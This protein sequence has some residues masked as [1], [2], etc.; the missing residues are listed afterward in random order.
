MPNFRKPLNSVLVKVAGPDC[1]M[2]CRY[3]F[4]LEKA[5]MFPS[6]GPRRMSRTVLEALIRQVMAD[7]GAQVAFGWQGG[8]PTLMGAAFFEEVVRLEKRWGRAG[9]T[10]GNGLQTN[11]LRI[12]DAW[13]RVLR[14]GRFLVGLSLD[15][16]AH[17]HDHYRVTAGGQGTWERV[18]RARRRLL[19]AG[20]E[21]NALTVV[22]DY[23]AR[24]AREIYEFHKE[25][26]LT[27][28]QFI[29]CVEPDPRTRGRPADFSVAPR[30]YG[31]FLCEL[32]DCWTADFED[33][34]ATTSVRWFDS[35][36]ATYVDVAAPECT[37]LGECGTY[38]VI[39][40]N[41][42]VF[43][44]D[45]FVED[46]WRL[47]NVR[48]GRLIEMLNSPRQA[49]FGRRKAALPHACQACPW[50]AHCRG[51]CPKERW[52][53]PADAKLSYLCDGYKLFFSH[54]DARLRELAKRWRREHAAP[55][56]TRLAP[57]APAEAGRNDPCPCGSG[58][59]YKRCCGARG[60]P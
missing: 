17:V 49:E 56:V 14:E 8:E 58:R 57:E 39:E 28:M 3:C 47:G 34:C 52:G 13:C 54:A 1:N 11:G 9:Q 44:C 29:P 32:F 42:D 5:E 36:F 15:G 12:D 23:S 41:G 37:L 46:R 4:Y 51:G 10:V 48:E 24:C 45:F 33:G 50:L 22:S 60:R 31:E 35:V 27:F 55:T 25:N 16:P 6:A 43:S 53:N 7:G 40:H 20:V 26:G 2:A 18:D 30:A 19:D 59:K 21:V 38:V